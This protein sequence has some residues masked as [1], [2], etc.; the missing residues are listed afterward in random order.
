MI[1][2]QKIHIFLNNA[3]PRN[4]SRSNWSRHEKPTVSLPDDIGASISYVLFSTLLNQLPLSSQRDWTFQ[5]YLQPPLKHFLQ[6][7]ESPVHETS[8]A[9]FHAFMILKNH[10]TIE[11]LLFLQL[12]KLSPE[13]I[14]CYRKCLFQT[15]K[16][17]YVQYIT[18]KDQLQTCLYGDLDAFFTLF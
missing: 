14:R 12:L 15:Q 4:H 5:R 16:N 18:F 3:K 8:S 17:I 7:Q 9:Y 13:C 10:S 11:M 2:I 6:A 1:L